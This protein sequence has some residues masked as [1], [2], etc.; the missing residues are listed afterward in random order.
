MAG[1]AAEH[2]TVI[3]A[4]LGGLTSAC[5]VAFGARAQTPVPAPNPHAVQPERPTVAT[6]AGTVATGWWEIETGVERDAIAPSQ[7]ALSTPTVF[8]IGIASHAQLSIAASTVRPPGSSLGFGDAS[9]G[10]KWR[11]LDDAPILGDFA[12]LPSIKFPTGSSERG[13]G[14][15]DAGLL[16]ISSHDLGP[17]A[18]D[19]NAGLTR[20]SG[21][22][23][24]A[25]KTAT[26]WTASFGGP[27]AGPIGWVAECFGLPGTGGPAGSAPSV[28]LLAGPT[29]LAY[30]WLAFDAGVIVPVLGPQPHAVYAGG[31]YN[32]GRLWRTSQR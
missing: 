20:R 28:A 30:E 9:V 7:T 27:I 10:V 19:L 6:H 31:V 4:L 23:R 16:L 3:R 13:T 5:T 2:H 21:D 25:P 8:K 1:A 22:G 24:D 18:M 29:Y 14:T 32:I 17:V 11:L 15:T 12:V 26:L